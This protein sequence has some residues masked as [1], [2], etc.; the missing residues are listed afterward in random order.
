MSHPNQGFSEAPHPPYQPPGPSPLVQKTEIGKGGRIVIPAAMRAALGV[1]E[2]E[3][4]LLIM[5]GDTLKVMSYFGNLR[6]MQAEISALGQP[7]ASWVDELIA[8]RR[9]EAAR[10][11]DEDL[12]G[13]LPEALQGYK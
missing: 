9:R 4:L 3:P 1:K 2:G 6:K 8:D 10:E 7:G 11:W 5:E 13:P 12:L